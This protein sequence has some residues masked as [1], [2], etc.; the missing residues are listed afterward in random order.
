MRRAGKADVETD[1]FQR[2]NAHQA[3]YSFFFSSR[4]LTVTVLPLTG[5]CLR[6]ADASSWSFR[7]VHRN[8]GDPLRTFLDLLVGDDIVK[9]TDG[10]L[11][12][13]RMIWV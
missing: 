13:L 12:I 3:R 2:V 7:S 4:R 5:G 9:E 8:A 11:T 10:S 6:P 1:R